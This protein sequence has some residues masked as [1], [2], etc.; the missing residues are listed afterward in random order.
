MAS[1]DDDRILEP[2]IGDDSDAEFEFDGFTLD[3]IEYTEA[4]LNARIT[5]KNFPIPSLDEDIVVSDH[6]LEIDSLE[7]WTQN[8]SSPIVVPF[9]GNPGLTIELPEYRDPLFYFNLFIKE[10]DFDKFAVETNKYASVLRDR[11]VC[12]MLLLIIIVYTVWLRP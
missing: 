5:D 8:Y 3:E 11:E 12:I 1:A 2:Y 9:T 10:S 7:G 6:I 4:I